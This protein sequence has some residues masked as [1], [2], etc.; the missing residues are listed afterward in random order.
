LDAQEKYY[1][2]IRAY[3]DALERDSRQPLVL[4]NLAHTY[5]NQ[6]RL[7]MARQSLLQAIEMDPNLAASHEALGYCLFRSRDFGAAERAYNQALT[8]DW[9]LPR[10]H[11]GLGSIYM[12]RFLEDKTQTEPRDRALEHWHRSLEF[13][14]DQPRIRKLI[15]EYKP[16]GD[17]PES[18]L[19]D[20]RL[21]PRP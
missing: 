14:P 2:A 16:Q 10:S 17:D 6:D 1:E 21:V 19:L 13:N 3:R 12:I 20:E 15:A 4:V 18:L 7:K 5:M 11:A 9:R 8:C